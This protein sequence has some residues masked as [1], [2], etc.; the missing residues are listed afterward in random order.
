MFTKTRIAK[1]SL[2]V[3]LIGTAQFLFFMKSKE[4]IQ[5][6]DPGRAAQDITLGNENLE[7]LG[8]SFDIK[9]ITATSGV[10]VASSV[11]VTDFEEKGGSRTEN[12]HSSSVQGNTLFSADSM[13]KMLTSATILRMTEEGKYS[14][15]LPN[16]VDTK[17]SDLL[18]ILKKR[19]PN[20]TYIGE[21]LE[22]QPNFQN[23]TIAHLAQHTSGLAR[24]SRQALDEAL[25]E[26]PKLTPEQ[27]IDT[28]KTPRTG[29]FGE[30][31]G[32]YSYND[33]GY[34]LLG[35]VVTAIASEQKQS[36]V[37]FGDV[38]NELVI[39]RVK[40]KLPP[41]Q[42]LSLQ[43]FTSD[44]MEDYQGKTRVKARP[45]LE[46]T[47]GKDYKDGSFKPVPSHSYDLACGGS[48]TDPESMSKIAFHVLA[49]NPDFSI[50]KT[51]EALEVLNSRQMPKRNPDGSPD[52]QGKTYG[53]G[54]ESFGHPDY[55]HL[56]D[57]GGLGYGSNSNALVD[58]KANKAVVVMTAF[59]NLTLPLA[60]AIINEEKASEPVRLDVK[61]FE[62]SKELQSR[63]SE[64]QLVLMRNSLEKSYE[65][66]QDVYQKISEVE[67]KESKSR[68]ETFVEKLGLSEKEK[69]RS[70]VE[71]ATAGKYG[72][73]GSKDG[74]HEL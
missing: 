38:V 36:V 46:A 13:T 40:E 43:F 54:Y 37:S 32:E 48:Y 18:P 56:R 68:E 15:F 19:Y 22:A 66:F 20:S 6:K 69:P 35:R 45:D 17:L 25:E 21:E 14:E 51:E 52:K 61:L 70:F 29:K 71:A 58:T 26:N 49:S 9:P 57:H 62:K 67:S 28:A 72:N 23:I 53:F 59:E 10:P 63:Y 44:Q 42:A 65:E 74:F 11:A 73:I 33:L 24:V 5:F 55:S 4:P 39:D 47:F 12:R 31:I 41:E 8:S 3:F 7:N 64:E 34:E 27:M 50:Y 1:I 16:G 60:Y 2:L 30:N